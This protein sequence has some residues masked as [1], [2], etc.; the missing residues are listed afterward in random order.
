[1]RFGRRSN[2]RF[3]DKPLFPRVNAMKKEESEIASSPKNWLLA[4]T[5]ENQIG[6]PRP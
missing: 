1:M 2:L 6:H 3:I 5:A 4:K